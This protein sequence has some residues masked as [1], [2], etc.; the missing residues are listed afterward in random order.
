MWKLNAQRDSENWCVAQIN[1]SASLLPQLS[2]FKHSSN[3]SS[4]STAT[5]LRYVVHGHS[6]TDR[7]TAVKIFEA[8]ILVQLTQLREPSLTAKEFCVY[9]PSMQQEI[10]MQ[11][12]ILAI[13]T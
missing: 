10:V 11:L 5:T 13:N 2:F 7:K 8:I 1:S 6:F 3:N 12:M 9:F 4:S